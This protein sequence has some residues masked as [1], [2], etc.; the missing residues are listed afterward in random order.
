MAFDRASDFPT[1]REAKLAI[2]LSGIVKKKNVLRLF[3]EEVFSFGEESKMG[4]ALNDSFEG[5]DANG[6][7]FN[8]F[9]SRVLFFLSFFHKFL[10]V[11][12]NEKGG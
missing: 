6:L 7:G 11:F 2:E 5:W 12:S 8:K 4:I 1:A 10:R 3:G 9:G